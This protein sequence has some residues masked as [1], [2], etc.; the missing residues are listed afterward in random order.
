MP[1]ARRIGRGVS[2]ACLTAGL[3]VAVMAVATRSSSVIAF[4]D[5]TAKP[6]NLAAVL[7]ND[8]GAIRLKPV[9]NARDI[10]EPRREN[11]R[12]GHARRLSGSPL[13]LQCLHFALRRRGVLLLVLLNAVSALYGRLSAVQQ[14]L[15]RRVE[16]R[17]RD[18]RKAIAQRDLLLREVHHRVKN[19]L[20]IA[21]SLMAM[22]S[23][24]ISDR[25]TRESLAELRNRVCTLGLV[26]QQL[27]AADSSALERDGQ[28][29]SYHGRRRRRLWSDDEKRRIVAETLVPGA[30]ISIVARRHDL[31]ANMLFTWR[32]Q[33]G[34][35]GFP[36]AGDAVTFVPAAITAEAAPVAS[37]ATSVAGR[38]EIVL[39]DGDRII[40]GKDVD[41]A[42]LARVVK[43]LSRR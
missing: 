19:N 7:A 17:T 23:C 6:K 29:A 10:L 43:I 34:A 36:S 15:E 32:R 2:L 31:N 16:E 37:P 18:L 26:H 28:A 13:R 27:M 25:S 8:E 33:I 9:A 5:L 14:A 1:P 20:Q 21:D 12:M 30:S 39:A 4:P 41:A 38:M 3:L 11:R 22:E 42:A 24:V 40:V 35:A